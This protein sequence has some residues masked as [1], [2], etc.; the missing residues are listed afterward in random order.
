M[1]DDTVG[2]P[3]FQVGARLPVYGSPGELPG[4]EDPAVEHMR[5]LEHDVTFASGSRMITAATIAMT[6][7]EDGARHEVRLEP[8]FTFRMKGIGYSHPEWVHGRWHDELVVGAES[9]LL[10]EVDDSAFENQHCQHL[11][12][13]VYTDGSGRERVGIGVL[14]QNLLGPYKPYGLEG[15]FDAPVCE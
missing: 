14:E 9:W 13:A 7:V 2:R 3:L 4:V 8:I 10:A 1:F 5:N 12:R 6:S 15:F 11:V